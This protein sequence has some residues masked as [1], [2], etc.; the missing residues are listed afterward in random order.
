MYTKHGT[1]SGFQNFNRL[2]YLVD[3]SD[4]REDEKKIF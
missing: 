2:A 3:W 1:G 4:L